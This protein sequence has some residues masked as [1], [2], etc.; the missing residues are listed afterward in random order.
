MVVSLV[1]CSYQHG[2]IKV[3]PDFRTKRYFTAMRNSPPNLPSLLSRFQRQAKACASAP[4]TVLAVAL[5][6]LTGCTPSEEKADGAGD[7][8]RNSPL[9]VGT[10]TLD[11]EEVVITQELPARISSLRVAEVRSRVDG[12]VQKCCFE[13]GAFVK[14]GELLYQIDDASYRAAANRAKAALAKA[15]SNLESA[16]LKEKRYKAL[17]GNRVASQQEYEDAK[18]S[19]LACQADV[20]SAEAD[21]ESA[22]IDLNYTRVTAPVSGQIGK[23]E[24]TEGAYVRKDEAT[25]MATVRQNDPVYVDMT[26]SSANLVQLKQALHS[27]ELHRA[28]SSDTAR[29]T[30]ALENGADYDQEGIWKFTDTVTNANT[31][32]VTIRAVFPNPDNYLLPGMFV[33]AFIVEA[34]KENAIL[35]PQAVVMRDTKGEP[36]VYIAGKNGTAEQKSI[37]ISRSMGNRWLV[38]SGLNKGDRIIVDHLQ[39]MADGVPIVVVDVSGQEKGSGEH[40]SNATDC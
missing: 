19:L 1:S 34:R 22:L 13:E 4:A 7:P 11:T 14:E 32:S 12:I 37:E 5:M 24:I 3:I 25:L 9:E 38:N 35:I 29:V 17:L 39:K 20:M 36:Y 40:S 31:S 16:E 28:D 2:N 21:L 33:K 8:M 18:A 27:N 10:L 23:S 15:R 30:L 6:L 26:Q